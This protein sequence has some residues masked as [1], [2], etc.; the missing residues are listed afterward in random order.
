MDGVHDLGG[1]QGFGPLDIDHDEHAFHHDWEARMWGLNEAMTGDPGWAIDWWRHVRELILPL[2]Y[3]SR[4]YFDQWAQIYAA[5]LIDSGIASL[6]EVA[7]GKATGP[8]PAL[9]APMQAKD[10]AQA[11]RRTMDFRRDG[12]AKSAFANGQKVRA[13]PVGAAGHTRLPRYVRGRPGLIHAYH[14][15]HL[16]PDAGAKGQERAEPLYAVVF[17]AADLWPERAASRDRI[18]LDFWESYLEP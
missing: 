5:L 13:R 12:D 8:R 9:G 17:R 2:D 1:V 14:G 11:S 18:F 16:L 15:N 10:V 3:L 4:P 7:S 6:A